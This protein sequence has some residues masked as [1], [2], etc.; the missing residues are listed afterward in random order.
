MAKG[1]NHKKENSNQFE[2]LK[3]IASG[4]AHEIKNPL[5]T[6]NLNLQILLEDF[7]QSQ[8]E[9]EKKA[10]KRIKIIKD[11]VQ[12]L[13]HIVNEFLN[14]A[15][16][17]K[18]K[19]ELTNIKKLINSLLNFVEPELNKAKITVWTEFAANLPLVPADPEKIKQALLNLI[20]NSRDS[21]LEKG[22]GEIFIKVNTDDEWLYIEIIDTGK[23]IPEET[24]HKIFDAYFSTKKKG[25]GLGLATT[26][27][28]IENH[29]GA[30][31]LVASEVGTGTNFRIKLPLYKPE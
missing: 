23:G 22:A 14:F 12:R 2:V 13:E 5:S 19:I 8:S 16:E 31:E 18:P 6:M 24:Q 20:L 26:K 15:R 1:R 4:L 10:L 7:E 3:Q 11:E 29:K 30:L 9:T 27:R 21:I 25:T 17:E 28:I